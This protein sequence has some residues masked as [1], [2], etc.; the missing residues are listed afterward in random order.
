MKEKRVRYLLE[1]ITF[2]LLLL[3]IGCNNSKEICGND[4]ISVIKESL[5]NDIIQKWTGDSYIIYP[6]FIEF[7]INK[8]F[9]EKLSETEE[10]NYKEL[11]L[12][13]TNQTNT[14]FEN[15]KK[16]INK[17]YLKEYCQKLGHL[18]TTDSS[19]TVICFSGISKQLF[20]IDIYNFLGPPL[21]NIAENF[22][23]SQK[24]ISN[25]ASFAIISDKEGHIK[26]VEY[27]FSSAGL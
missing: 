6:Y 14:S 27:I 25:K 4:D 10:E 9:R 12:K 11:F 1:I 8:S 17:L 2:S 15:L 16:R 19:R 7:G 5:N 21:S 24:N 22:D 13:K 3:L 20:F 18:S 26:S 23:F